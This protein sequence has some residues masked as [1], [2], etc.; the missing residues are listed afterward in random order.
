[1]AQRLYYLFSHINEHGLPGLEAP[2][3]TAWLRDSRNMDYHLKL[4]GWLSHWSDNSQGS[5]LG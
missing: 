1:M 4:R 3:S 5:T 2:L